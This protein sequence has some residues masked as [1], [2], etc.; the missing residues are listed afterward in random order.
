MSSLIFYTDQRQAFCATDTL[1]TSDGQPFMFTTKAFILPHL[2]M[3]ICGTGVGGFLG[4]WFIQVNDGM[5]VSDIEHLDH[6]TPKNL[7]TLWRTHKDQS[8]L[9]TYM[10]TTVYH[11]GFSSQDGLIHS[12][13]YRSANNFKSESLNYGIGVKPEC[14]VDEGYELP[15]DVRKMMGEQRVIQSSK[16][17]ENRIHIGGQILVH[18]LTQ[19]GV[20]AYRLDQFDD[21][22]STQRTIYEN[23]AFKQSGVEG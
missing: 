16:P 11:F 4:K 3:I 23:F 17:E 12:Y 14:T 5:I 10:T 15:A 7:D 19:L 1:A 6:H 21:F 9:P 20:T 13:A 18:H 8:S 2:Q 22:D